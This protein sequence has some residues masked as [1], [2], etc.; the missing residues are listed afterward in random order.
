MTTNK[1][2]NIATKE[3]TP[4]LLTALATPFKHGKVHIKSL[5]ALL[6]LQNNADVDG[7]VALGTTAESGLMTDEEKALILSATKLLTNKPLVVGVAANGEY[8]LLRQ[9]EFAQKHGA[10]A[11]LVSP[12]SFCK[13]TKNGYIKLLLKLHRK[14]DLPLVL[15]NVPSRAAYSL[16]N[17]IVR[18]LAESG[19]NFVKEC[20]ADGKLINC[21]NN[22]L[23]FSGND[24]YLTTHIRQGAIGAI[25]VASNIFPSLTKK[26]MLQTVNSD[27]RNNIEST[28]KV[29]TKF[30]KVARLCA[31]EVN[32][33]ATKYMLYRLGIFATPEM[34]LPL[35][36]ADRQTRKQTDEFLKE[37]KYEI[38]GIRQ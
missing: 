28:D 4:L 1:F 9:A 33:I 17:I 19:V 20:A 38:D 22:V 2:T 18:T 11:L 12:P 29:A 26:V 27:G 34:R 36:V 7:L 35:T 32:P 5:D 15:Y 13:C 25:S 23:C 31:L 14:C 21:A 24:E 16:D 3:N 37:N 10:D 6:S 8:T 30:A